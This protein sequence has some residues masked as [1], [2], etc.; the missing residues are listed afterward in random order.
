MQLNKPIS[1]NN[2]TLNLAKALDEGI[3]FNKGELLRGQV[4]EV[5]DNGLVSI[6]IKGKLIEAFSEVMVNRGQQLY[7]MVDDM[8]DGRVVLKVMTPE[9]LGKIENANLASTL[10]EIGIAPEQNNLQMAKKLIQHNLPVNND[11]IK[12]MARG[13]SLLGA[14]TPKNLEIV[15]T[16]LANNTP[17]SKA[18]LTAMA[19]F[20]DNKADLA[21]VAKELMTVL[22]KVAD[23]NPALKGVIL[24]LSTNTAAA[25][26]PIP[27][28]MAANVLLTA[29]KTTMP[30]LTLNQA[31]P[32]PLNPIP[33]GGESVSL[34]NNP[35]TTGLNPLSNITGTDNLATATNVRALTLLNQL[36]NTL[37]VPINPDMPANI[38]Q[39]IGEALR[40][41]LTS[42][43]DLLK[44]LNLVKDILTQKEIPGI[45]KGLISQ[46]V[47]GIEEMEREVVGTKMFNVMTKF[48]ADNNFNYYYFSFPVKI[49]EEYRLCQLKIDKE[50]GMNSLRDADNVKFI[51][52]LDTKNLGLVLFHVDWHK[53]QMLNL[54]GVVETP[55]VKQKIESNVNGLIKTLQAFGYT[56]DYQGIKIAALDE[57]LMRVKLQETPEVVKPFVIDIRV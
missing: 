4:Q 57:E 53:N 5:K 27:A 43:K 22:N 30:N 39:E 19:N 33:A 29:D 14:A 13:V 56:V 42:E 46:L 37:I 10:K 20:V 8:R 47:K 54:Q 32:S 1:F 11:T 52:S 35:E 16:A 3:S 24:N 51:V 44:G 48:S 18:A 6:F 36:V 31:A 17:V 45:E 12:A 41:A 49:N 26:R 34:T 9:L 25:D 2:F 7:L 23:A 40:T 55:A 21:N 50:S 15:G 28:A 38:R